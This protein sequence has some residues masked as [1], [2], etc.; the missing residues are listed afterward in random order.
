MN[1]YVQHSTDEN[2]GIILVRLIGAVNGESGAD[3]RLAKLAEEG[4]YFDLLN[5]GLFASLDKILS[6]EQTI[7]SAFT[8]GFAMLMSMQE[9]EPKQVPATV[10]KFSDALTKDCTLHATLK[11]RLLTTLFNTL[12]NN[13]ILRYNIFL[14]ILKFALAANLSSSLVGQFE[15]MPIWIK[16]WKLN[17]TEIAELYLLISQVNKAARQGEESQQYLLKYLCV[18]ETCGPQALKDARP[19]AAQAVLYVLR[20][21][22]SQHLSVSFEDLQS[23]AAVRSLEGDAQSGHLYALL[24]IFIAGTVHEYE[25]LPA[26]VVDKIVEDGISRDDAVDKL[27]TLTLCGLTAKVSK[28]SYAEVAEQLKLK[29]NCEVEETII[30]AV[31]SGRIEAQLNQHT[32]SVTVLRSTERRVTAESWAAVQAKLAS[33]RANL[34]AVLGSLQNS[35]TS[36]DE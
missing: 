20:A 34:T 32:E 1:K 24:E 15:S 33:W 27:R 9:Q 18:A 31:H 35:R 28:L 16:L 2:P 17:A 23:F 30:R 4:K 29:D 13:S 21:P 6:T 10:T 3:S 25:A 19:H 11:N 36:G 8:L 26:A 22:L 14:S 12:E 5:E 7:E